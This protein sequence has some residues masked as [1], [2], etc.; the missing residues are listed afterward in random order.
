[1][2][3][4]IKILHLEDENEGIDQAKEAVDVLREE[5]IHIEIILKKSLEDAL[6]IVDFSFDGAIIDLNL[7]ENEAAGID[8]IKKLKE[9]LSRIPIIIHTGT[10]DDA[11]DIAD[12]F[13]KIYRKGETSYQDIF[14]YFHKIY[15]TGLTKVIGARGSFEDAIYKVY[16]ESL[17]PYIDKWIEYATSD[18]K[19]TERC[20]LRY[21]LNNIYY[22]LNSD[23]DTLYP[24]ECYLK[25]Q[26]DKPIE[27]G[28]L[29]KYKNRNFIIITPACDL[30]N[31][32]TMHI[33]L[34]EI[35]SLEKILDEK[36]FV[37]TRAGKTELSKS[38]AENEKNNLTKNNS[39]ENYHY[40]PKTTVFIGG[41]IN[42]R[43]IHSIDLN[44]FEKKCKENRIEFIAQISP[45]FVKDI[46]ARFSSYYAR[47][48]QPNIM[49]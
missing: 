20:L 9:L 31:C 19:R 23:E 41:C 26:S 5:G 47:Q 30:A 16:Q 18:P 39:G 17:L 25:Y 3:N 37:R 12:G 2:N 40:L 8:Y 6:E 48:G 49:H 46:I 43:K 11:S 29:C 36:N 44:S 34:I 13:V 14:K 24:E 15:K 45:Y 7:N 21:T 28:L 38:A 27:T 32:K 4:R 1:M 35:D 22:I 33:Q 10:P 42:F